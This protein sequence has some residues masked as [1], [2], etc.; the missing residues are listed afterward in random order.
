MEIELN[1]IKIREL[2][3]GYVDDGEGG[4]KGYS[5][6]LD[7]RPPF[8]REFVYDDKQR[9]AVID[10]I[11]KG[12]PLNI[13]YWADRGNGTYEII[14]GQQRTVSIAKYVTGDF[15]LNNL[16]FHNQPDDIQE[17]IL[18]YELMVY[19]CEGTNSE[20][21]EWFKIVNIAGERLFDQ[22]IRNAVYS[23]SWVSDAKRY[24]SRSGCAA[25]GI[26]QNYMKGT[27]IRQDYL[28]TVINWISEEN[29]EDYMGKHQHNSD[30]KELW[31]YFEDV[32][33]W[34]EDNFELR[35]KIMKGVDWGIF[36]N[37]FKDTKLDPEDIEEKTAELIADDDVERKQGIYPYI[38]TGEE[39]HLNI[40]T[41]TQG[42]KQKVYEKQNGKCKICNEPFEIG[43]M[44]ADHI[45]PWVEGG[46]T[47]EDNCQLLCKDCNRRKSAK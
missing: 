29:I 34:I 21:L 7:I 16:F 42:M 45:T 10:T 23:G 14:D 1:E 31:E 28:E 2:V 39:K 5:G 9:D 46:K 36:Y 44:E 25:Y 43:G 26:G 41:F 13:M 33:S 22:E 32:V 24:F 12:F 30:A 20:K 3:A 37:K 15:S 18:N 11:M 8:Q 6:H 27:P 4:V 47:N 17:K 40:R 35:K 19:F 38:L